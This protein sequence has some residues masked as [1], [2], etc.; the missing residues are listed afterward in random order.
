MLFNW[1]VRGS[2]QLA[3]PERGQPLP[4]LALAVGDLG[5]ATV[6]AHST[7]GVETCLV[8]V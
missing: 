8:T 1:Y 2:E 7:H 5:L 4:S 3:H 6:E